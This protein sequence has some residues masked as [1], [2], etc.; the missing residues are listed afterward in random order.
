MKKKIEMAICYDFDG[1]LSPKNMQEASFIPKLRMSS[2]EFWK[3][4]KECGAR[5]QM[6]PILAYM[7]VMLEE[8]KHCHI[9][10]QRKD[11]QKHGKGI[12]LFKGVESWFGRINAYAAERGVD[13]K[14]YLISS[15]LKEMVEGSS[16]AQ[17]FDG[18]FASSFQYDANDV[19]EWPAVAINYTTKTQYLF[20]IN[21][22]CFDLADNQK[23]NQYVSP[24]NRPIPFTQMI[25]IGDGETDVPCMRLVKSAGGH[26]IAVY[27][28]H[29]KNAK[30]KAVSFVKDGR[31]NALLAANYEE[32]SPLDKFIK[33]V[34]DKVVIEKRLEEGKGI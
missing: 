32:N 10:I 31:V 29:T 27:R 3:K 16:I 1:T 22:G 12:P 34:I 6:D 28:P 8:A 11:F 19:A 23:I 7:K 13:L 33:N 30:E 25:Y 20:R 4:A 9:S 17:S 14:H 15:G 2:V 21:K 18:I 26:S 24:E 5:H